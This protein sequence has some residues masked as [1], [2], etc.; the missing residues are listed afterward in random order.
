MAFALSFKPNMKAALVVG[1]LAGGGAV[2]APNSAQAACVSSADAG[3]NACFTFT[4]TTSSFAVQTYSTANLKTNQYAQF[5]FI[6]NGP[7]VTLTG[8]EYSFDS[9]STWNT[10]GTGSFAV[11]STATYGSV[12][13]DVLIQPGLKFRYTI[14]TGL[15]V[16]DA[17]QSTLLTNDNGNVGIG[18]TLISSF[19]N[20]AQVE[21]LSTAV[22]QAPDAAP[23]PLPVLGAAA[24]FSASRRLRRRIQSAA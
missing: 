15:S 24:A 1:L 23:G 3:A 13:N 21:R 7:S 9:G 16:N 14:P 5:G 12:I 22:A 11:T 19:N 10:Y 4:P 6:S 17:I 8:V 20:F 2:F 18:T